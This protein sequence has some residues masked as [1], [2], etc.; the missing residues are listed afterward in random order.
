MPLICVELR[1]LGDKRGSCQVISSVDGTSTARDRGL[2]WAQVH[3]LGMRH[4][5]IL[6]IEYDRTDQM[7]AIYAMKNGQCRNLQLQIRRGPSRPLG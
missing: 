5:S 4:P 7:A 3:H 2:A 1:P 6:I